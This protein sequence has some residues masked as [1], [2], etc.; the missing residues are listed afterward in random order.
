MPTDPLVLARDV[1]VEFRRDDG[2]F[3]RRSSTVTAV[4]GVT[5]AIMK[6]ETVGLVGESGCGKSTLARALLHLVP[7]TRG[8]VEYEG[9]D[10]ADRS[11]EQ[12]RQMRRRFQIIFQ[13]PYSSLNPRMTV[14]KII[15][16]PLVVHGIAPGRERV[17][18]VVELLRLVGLDPRAVNRYP[19]E[20]S[21]GQRQRISIARVLAVEPQ[22]IVADEPISALDVSIQAQLLNLLMDLQERFELTYLIVAH[23]L[24]VVA[25]ISDRVAV[26]YLGRIVELSERNDLF[27][28]PHHPYTVALL[29]A[30]PSMDP[31]LEHRRKRIIF[32]GDVAS[33]V[34]PPSG[35]RFHPRC[36][37]RERLGRPENCAT[38]SPPLRDVG[39][40]QVACHWAEEMPPEVVAQAVPPVSADT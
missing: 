14:G 37:L 35:C 24:A 10:L 39:G 17:E 19:H 25:H 2:L 32:K 22:F 34:N 40:H 8:S 20:F 28:R 27:M 36:W 26:M 3:R 29:S 33:A 21:G 30:V 11:D 4:D 15:G 12:L 31:I 7:L 5:L 6:G 9:S 38:E 23:D 18:R 16:E 13:D 1:A